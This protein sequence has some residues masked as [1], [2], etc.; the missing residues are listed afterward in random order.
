MVIAVDVSGSM[1]PEKIKNVKVAIRS[2]IDQ[3]PENGSEIAIIAF[4]DGNYYLSDF[5]SNKAKLKEKAHYLIEGGDTD[6]DA[7]FIS[8]IAGALL[9]IEKAKFDNRNVILVTDGFATGNQVEISNMALNNK[10]RIY[11]LV[12][13]N[14]APDILINISKL[15]GG[16]TYEYIMNENS[17][18][19][20][21]SN[22]L[23][24][25]FTDPCSIEWEAANNCEGFVE[26]EIIDKINGLSDINK[27][28]LSNNLRSYF[29]ILPSFIDFGFINVGETKDTTVIIV[30]HNFDQQLIGTSIT[31]D[32]G[33]IKVLN[34]FPITIEKDKHVLLKLRCEALDTLRHY[35]K[36]DLSFE[37]CS[38][39]V[40]I[41]LGD[42]NK[43]LAEK[44]LKLLHP[45]GAEVFI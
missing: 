41:T 3:M 36:L 30:A 17:L 43:N 16:K 12:L 39:S 22:T 44:T 20:A 35:I 8:P 27:F 25:I 34:A 28:R 13:G 2:F 9:A 38:F 14:L 1:G 10:T 23:F 18:K 24:H 11:S 33:N 37:L 19:E 40:G 31:N 5:S 15:T 6:F 4:N 26:L 7:A 32:M 42:F 45:N 21:F 29:E